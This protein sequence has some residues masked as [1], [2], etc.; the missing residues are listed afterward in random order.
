MA[1]GEK[2]HLKLYHFFYL[3]TVLCYRP[4]NI[5]M[6]VATYFLKHRFASECKYR[7]LITFALC[8]D[9]QIGLQF[10]CEARGGGYLR[11]IDRYQGEKK[12]FEYPYKYL[13]KS[14]F[15]H[16]HT[17]MEQ[18]NSFSAFYGLKFFAIADSY[19]G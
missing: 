11:N 8:G 15:Q 19:L 9:T 7:R 2:N 4:D 5:M 14:D 6:W 12:S 1:F 17:C 13:L 10:G 16:S 3:L 18:Y